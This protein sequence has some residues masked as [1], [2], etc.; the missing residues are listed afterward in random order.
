MKI[1]L[2]TY[3]V[4]YFFR[5]LDHPFGLSE[6]KDF[7]FKLREK[8]MIDRYHGVQFPFVFRQFNRVQTPGTL[9]VSQNCCV[10][11]EW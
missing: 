5:G 4:R 7:L 6:I 3:E 8:Q 9:E 1:S 2:M 11:F 10:P